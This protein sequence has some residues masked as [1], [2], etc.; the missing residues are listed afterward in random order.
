MYFSK[1]NVSLCITFGNFPKVPFLLNSHAATE[2]S[3]ATYTERTVRK[4]SCLNNLLYNSW[5]GLGGG[6]GR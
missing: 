3:A 6:G 1:N 4:K 2:S 5:G